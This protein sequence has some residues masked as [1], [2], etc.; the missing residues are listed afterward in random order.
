MDLLLYENGVTEAA[1]R[2]HRVIESIIPIDHMEIHKTV[3]SLA[4]RLHRPRCELGIAVLMPSSRE[5]H[6]EIVAIKDLFDGI[7]I[8]LI[9]PDSRKNIVSK[10]HALYPRFLSYADGDFK[11][12]AAVLEKM[13]INTGTRPYSHEGEVEKW[14]N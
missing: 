9:L 6:V 5:D 11:D 2:L 4:R 3:K 12:V 7:R 14:R 13:L 10:G 1:E 8:I